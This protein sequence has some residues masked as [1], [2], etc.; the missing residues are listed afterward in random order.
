MGVIHF[1]KDAVGININR[2]YWYMRKVKHE[3]SSDKS[4]VKVS[5]SCNHMQQG[6]G[7]GLGYKFVHADNS[8]NC[9]GI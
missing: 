6:S 8:F 4:Q 2:F 7:H 3:N 1:I 5:K 9:E